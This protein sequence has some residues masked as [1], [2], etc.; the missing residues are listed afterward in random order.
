VKKIIFSLC[1]LVLSMQPQNSYSFWSDPFY[2]THQQITKVA[3]TTPNWETGK[4]FCFSS[5]ICAYFSDFAIARI[6]V[7]HLLQDSMAY[8]ANDHFDSN[9]LVGSLTKMAKNRN[10]LNN[11]FMAGSFSPVTR[12]QMWELMG[13]MLHAAEDFYAHSTWVDAGNTSR[14]INFGPATKRYPPDTSIFPSSPVVQFCGSDGYPLS[15]FPVSYL[16]TGYYPPNTPPPSGGCLHGAT[17]PTLFSLAINDPTPSLFGLCDYFGS[18]PLT[19]PGIAHDVACSG[20][21]I[22]T[23]TVNL[24][25]AAKDLAVREAQSFVQSIVDDLAA[26][27][28]L[29][30]F[31][32]LLDATETVPACAFAGT[33]SGTLPFQLQGGATFP[34]N[35]TL[36]TVS[37]GVA[38]DANGVSAVPVPITYL[39]STS[40][41]NNFLTDCPIGPATG[42]ST[43]VPFG[44]FYDWPLNPATLCAG[45]GKNACGPVGTATLTLVYVESGTT[46]DGGDTCTINIKLVAANGNV[47]GSALSGSVCNYTGK[48]ITTLLQS[49]KAVCFNEPSGMVCP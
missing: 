7:R 40:S 39:G 36:N 46:P 11:I 9:Q 16:I 1:I 21:F 30:G 47:T 32:A 34:G 3:L 27:N 24:H 4:P 15:T 28:N 41:A 19:V 44:K 22:P 6:N 8:D 14:I 31:C 48:G 33:V 43:C 45:D 10:Q 42:T 5:D 35:S 18:S 2:G 20:K 26:D 13:N 37:F 25:N 17:F 49:D 23:N 38:I 12:E 29:A